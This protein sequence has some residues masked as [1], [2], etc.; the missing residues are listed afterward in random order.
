IETYIVTHPKTKI[1][2]EIAVARRTA[3]LADLEKTK[4]AG[5]LT[6]LQEFVKRHPEHHLEGELAQ[7]THAVYLTALENYKKVANPKEAGASGTIE[8]VLGYFERKK[9][10]KLLIRFQRKIGKT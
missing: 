7:A 1:G 4:E 9:Q 8:R 2:P 6:A 10:N 5:T 3:M